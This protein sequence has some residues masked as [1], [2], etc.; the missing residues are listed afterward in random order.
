[1]KKNVLSII[2]LALLIV[3]IILTGIMMISMVSTNKKTSELV[4]DIAAVLS[5]ELGVK[6]G[7]EKEIPISQQYIW[8]LDGNMTIPLKSEDVLDS[9]GN[10]TGKKDHY[11]QFTVSFSLDM[12]GEGY[13]EYGGENIANYSS[14]V[15]DVITTTVS[16]H[17]IDECRSDFD[18]IKQDILENVKALFDKDFIYKVAINDLKYQ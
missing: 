6:E 10:V 14:L 3:N 7:E 4:G 1:M 9:E 2:I 13:E 15:K 12:K 17:T 11:V 18:V 16:K 8:N 5:L